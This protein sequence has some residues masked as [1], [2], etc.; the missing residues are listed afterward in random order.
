MLIDALGGVSLHPSER[1]S[2]RTAIQT[3]FDEYNVGANLPQAL[4]LPPLPTLHSVLLL[5][6]HHYACSY[7]SMERP[8]AG[9]AL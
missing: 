9:D 8:S 2:G 7:H 5:T 6:L 1:F 3:P 4:P